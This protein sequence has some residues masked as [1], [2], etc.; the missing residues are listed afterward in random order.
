MP[1]FR[2][3]W[4]NSLCE[5]LTEGITDPLMKA[6]AFYDFITKNMYYT[7][8]PSYITQEFLAES[9]AR[10]YTGDCAWPT[11]ILPLMPGW[12]SCL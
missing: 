7:F 9:C 12:K 5:E 3:S 11:R 1:V 10:N 2:G 8:M 6:R 4:H